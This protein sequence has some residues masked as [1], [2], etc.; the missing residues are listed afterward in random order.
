MK[1]QG[2]VEDDEDKQHEE[3]GDKQPV[4]GEMKTPTKRFRGKYTIHNNGTTKYGGWS[5]KGMVHFN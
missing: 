4:P 2:N 5:D 3:D 1:K